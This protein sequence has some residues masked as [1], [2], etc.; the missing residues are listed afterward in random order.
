MKQAVTKTKKILAVLMCIFMLGSFA[1]PLAGAEDAAKIVWSLENRDVVLNVP[2]DETPTET[3]LPEAACENGGAVKYV[4]CTDAAGANEINYPSITCETEKPVIKVYNAAKSFVLANGGEDGSC[5]IYIKA[6]SDST[7]SVVIKALTL[8][9]YTLN[10]KFLDNTSSLISETEVPYGLSAEKDAKAAEEKINVDYNQF[11]H[12]RFDG[13]DIVE[14]GESVEKII[15][16]TV[17]APVIEGEEHNF[18][19]VETVK[20]ASCTETGVEKLSCDCGYSYEREIPKTDHKWI[21]DEEGKEID[22]VIVPATCENGGSET[23]TCSVCGKVEITTDALGHDWQVKTQFKA[24]TCTENGTKEEQECTRCH[25]TIGGGVIPAPGH[26]EEVIAAVPAGCLTEGLTEGKKCSVCGETLLKQETVPAIGYHIEAIDEEKAPTC[27]EVGYTQGSHCSVCNEVFVPQK[28]IPALGHIKVVDVEAKAETCTEDGCT[29]GW[30]CER[31]GCGE[32]VESTV[33]E[34]H[35]LNVVVDKATTATCTEDGLS[36]GSH[37]EACGSVIVAQTVVEEK[38]GHIWFVDSV[39]VDATCTKTG[40]TEA[41]HCERE[42]CGYKEEATEVPCLPHSYV[43]AEGKEDIPA[44]CTE[45]GL[46]AERVCENCGATLDEEVIDALGH[47]DENND[48]ACD[49]CG[50]EITHIDPSANCSCICH[51][52]NVFKKFLWSKILL[53]IIKFL[54]VE[55]FCKCGIEHWSK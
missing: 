14:G 53:P 2:K 18:K 34:K 23:G 26:V 52:D 12:Y 55:R 37:C 24:A 3:T 50:A 30:H 41:G 7:S 25:K 40:L 31:E 10:V 33:V 38:L 44:T 45:T 22:H 35:H 28:E 19:N 48:N 16:D 27:T 39:A 36:E 47:I 42:G 9:N 20:E 17:F 4:L 8:K 54:G 21:V 43:I 13:W 49:R 1:V 11:M 29:E 5:P 46:K 51:S 15:S 32:K 6:Y